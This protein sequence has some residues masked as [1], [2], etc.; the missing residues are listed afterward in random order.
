VITA[1]SIPKPETTAVKVIRNGVEVGM[2]A[3]PAVPGLPGLYVVSYAGREA[4]VADDVNLARLFFLSALHRA[5]RHGG[6]EHD[7]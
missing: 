2:K 1:P 5:D 7:D 6:H 4:H 3:L